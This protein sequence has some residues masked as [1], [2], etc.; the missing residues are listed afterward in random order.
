MMLNDDFLVMI[1]P[2]IDKQFNILIS[3]AYFGQFWL[4]VTFEPNQTFVILIIALNKQSQSFIFI[5]ANTCLPQIITLRLTM[6][7]N[8]NKNAN[9][10]NELFKKKNFI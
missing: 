6:F 4:D 3:L 1:L 5:E 10:K 9:Y 7:L 2:E 8:F